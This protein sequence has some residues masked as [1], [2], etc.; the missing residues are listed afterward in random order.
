MITAGEKLIGLQT[1]DGIDIAY[2]VTLP[3][4]RDD[5]CIDCETADGLKAAVKAAR[6]TRAGRGGVKAELADGGY[7]F[8]GL[9]ADD[10]REREYKSIAYD[11][12]TPLLVFAAGEDGGP[13]TPARL[14]ELQQIVTARWPFET[15]RYEVYP[16][17][18]QRYATTI[19]YGSRYAWW[20]GVRLRGG[21]FTVNPLMPGDLTLVRRVR[22]RI[23]GCHHWHV[24]EWS[25]TYGWLQDAHQPVDSGWVSLCLLP[26]GQGF[27]SSAALA[28]MPANATFTFAALNDGYRRAGLGWG[29]Y[30]PGVRDSQGVPIWPDSRVEFPVPLTPPLQALKAATWY[31]FDLWFVYDVDEFPW[32][33][34]YSSVP[35]REVEGIYDPQLVIDYQ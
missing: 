32:R 28:A 13:R 30:S 5:T 11:F 31:L 22:V 7:A 4:E 18:H 6:V 16:P 3:A 14:S 27:T 15:A 26:H 1:G 29:N 23:S 9:N 24:Y 25:D 17:N 20:P 33:P 2:P 21:C 12:D 35:G 8:A 10:D 19:A 34:E